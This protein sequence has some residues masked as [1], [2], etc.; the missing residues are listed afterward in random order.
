VSLSGVCRPKLI[1]L[2]PP[3]T[4]I[5]C[6]NEKAGP[7]YANQEYSMRGREELDPGG[8]L[9]QTMY[10][11]GVALDRQECRIHN[12]EDLS[13][14]SFRS[15]QFR[16]N[17][18]WHLHSDSDASADSLIYPSEGENGQRV[19]RDFRPKDQTRPKQ[20]KIWPSSRSVV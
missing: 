20:R 4:G 1:L 6:Y 16:P 18:Y 10:C 3:L 9:T 11:A 15:A 5:L 8:R 14:C 13:R 17:L 2:T 7:T 19:R 12:V